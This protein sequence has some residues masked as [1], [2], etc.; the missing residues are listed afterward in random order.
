M[1][2]AAVALQAVLLLGADTAGDAVRATLAATALLTAGT[3]V[4]ALPRLDVVAF[5]RRRDVAL[6]SALT[7]A[8]L[9]V[10]LLSS[11]GIWLDEATSIWQAQMPLGQML[12]TLRGTDVHPPLHHLVL[13]ATVRVAGTG[14][15]A[16]R[17][18]SLIAS[19][20]LI[21][22]LYAAGRDVY[23]RRAGLVAAALGVVAPF[24][25]W[26]AQEARM[27]ALFMLFALLAAWLQV[28]ILRDG[29]TRDWAGYTVAAAALV[30]TQYFGLAL[31][32][33]QQ[34]IFLAALARDRRLLRGWLV[35]GAAL[36]LLLAP[37]LAFG[38]DQFAANEAAGKGF[39]QVPSQTGGAVASSVAEA[40]GPYA[41]LTNGVWAVLGYHGDATMTSLVALWPLLLLLALLLLGR[42]RSPRTLA[43]ALGAGVPALLLFGLGQLKPFVFEVRY[44]IGAVPIV[45]LLVAR[46][47]TSWSPRRATQAS[48]AAVAVALL[49]AGL[50]DQQ[51]NGD[52][53]RVYDFRG[54]LRDTAQR[55]RPGDV[56]VYTPAY[57]NHVV[58]YYAEGVEA[59]PLGEEVP[60]PARGGRVFVLASFLDKP[61]YRDAAAEAVRALD[62]R[63]ELVGER[64]YPQIRVWEFER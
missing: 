22:V 15:L 52:N 42:G 6:V 41:V 2:G 51:L 62:R 49:A 14:E 26:Y 53:P 31:V 8:G 57:L 29:R 59:R 36:A 61:Q 32:V 38:A 1:L 23:D 44:F 37:L 60:R 5:A 18:P 27:Y 16:V 50:A 55:A 9:A 64:R 10:R 19:T 11:R 46:A 47:A 35:A 39:Q 25:V 3:G 21:P 4:L 33:V 12:D 24:A 40:P 17:L 43:L 30:A 20:A 34:A 48:V 54:A 13:W 58:G 7:L 28:R 63:A 45:L 56:L